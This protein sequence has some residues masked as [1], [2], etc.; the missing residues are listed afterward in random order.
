MNFIYFPG[1][2]YLSFDL[3]F[4]YRQVSDADWGNER[5]EIDRQLKLLLGD[6]CHVGAACEIKNS[7]IMNRSNVSHQ[8]YVGDSV[9]GED[10][11]LGSGTKIANLKL[12][13]KSI[14]AV[15]NGLIQ[16]DGNLVLPWAI[17]CKLGLTLCLMLVA[18][19]VTMFL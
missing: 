14:T 4:N 19:L 5:D 17:M 10:C 6:E 2:P 1:L 7:I 18:W 12:D 16:K 11:N 3:D 9:I 15:A 8:N 13:K